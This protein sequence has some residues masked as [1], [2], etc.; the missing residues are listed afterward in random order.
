MWACNTAMKS[1]AFILSA[2]SF[3]TE[4]PLIVALR[5]YRVPFSIAEDFA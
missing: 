4:V 5:W 2:G 1:S 3:G